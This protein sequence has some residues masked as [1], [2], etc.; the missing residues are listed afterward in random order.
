MLPRIMCKYVQKYFHGLFM[1]C[2]KERGFTRLQLLQL[3]GVLVTIWNAS[4]S[5]KFVMSCYFVTVSLQRLADGEIVTDR[6]RKN[7]IE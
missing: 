4:Y 5:Y 1:D 2:K 3:V 6:R 7:W